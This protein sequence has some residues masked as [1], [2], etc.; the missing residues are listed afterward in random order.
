MPLVRLRVII[1]WIGSMI[2]YFGGIITII[3]IL[4]LFVAFILRSHRKQ[5]EK[6]EKQLDFEHTI[7]ESVLDRSKLINLCTESLESVLKKLYDITEVA[8]EGL[9][10]ENLKQ[11]NKT[12]KQLNKVEDGAMKLRGAAGKAL[13]KVHED[14]ME[15]AHLFIL[16]VDY[17]NEMTKHA[18][19]IMW[20]TN[21]SQYSM[22]RSKTCYTILPKQASCC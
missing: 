12:K 18:N 14:K 13:E 17:L 7:E 10:M 9:H 20:I 6:L 19:A 22:R 5:E 16:V 21:T 15:S 3:I 2:F 4:V 1:L 8:V 11:L